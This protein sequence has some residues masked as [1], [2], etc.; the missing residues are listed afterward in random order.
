MGVIDFDSLSIVG[1]S[2][3]GLAVGILGIRGHDLVYEVSTAIPR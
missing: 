3:C 1:Q 2:E